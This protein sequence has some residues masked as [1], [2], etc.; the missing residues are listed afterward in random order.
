M[1]RVSKPQRFCL[2]LVIVLI[3]SATSCLCLGLDLFIANSEPM[4]PMYWGFVA[5]GAVPAGA[6]LWL[7]RKQCLWFVF[8]VWLGTIALLPYIPYNPQKRFFTAGRSI[9]PGM[10]LAQVQAIMKAYKAE[11]NE[12]GYDYTWN[13][14]DI[15]YDSD[16]VY[17]A[18]ENGRVTR[19]STNLD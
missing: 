10:S 18:L 5:G 15:S 4:H 16:A 14:G 3:A 19:V 17:V 7:L 12:D 13:S 8:G 6:C 1:G 2:H 11:I 9:G